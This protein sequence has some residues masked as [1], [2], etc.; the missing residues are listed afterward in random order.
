MCVPAR[1]TLPCVIIGALALN[2]CETV[3]MNM[4][5]FGTLN[6][7]ETV[8]MNMQMFGT[9]NSLCYEKERNARSKVIDLTVGSSVLSKLSTIVS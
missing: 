8:L 2:S 4:Q 6:S 9:L 1:V 5:M 7:C 3:L